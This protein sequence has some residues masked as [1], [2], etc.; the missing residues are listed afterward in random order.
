MNKCMLP[1]LDNLKKMET[2]LE[3]HKVLKLTQED[4]ENL[5]RLITSKEIELAI[6][7]YPIKEPPGPDDHT[8]EFYQTYLIPILHKLFQK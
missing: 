3:K 4:V 8:S 7:K 2:F 1:K 6:K 5:N